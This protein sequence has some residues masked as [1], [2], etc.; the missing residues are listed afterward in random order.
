MASFLE[1]KIEEIRKE[2][3]YVRLRYVW[4]LVAFIMILLFSFW[5]ATLRDSFRP[6]SDAEAQPIKGAIPSSATDLQKDGQS[7][8]QM[9]DG[10]QSLSAEGLSGSVPA[11]GQ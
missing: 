2:P 6:P 9:V 10:A 8:R 7:I 1:R 4:G 3:E 11:N 5:V